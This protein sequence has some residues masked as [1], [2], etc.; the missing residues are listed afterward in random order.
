MVN[1]SG[2]FVQ[3]PAEVFEGRETFQGLEPLGE[4]VEVLTKS[5]RRLRNWSWVV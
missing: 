4:V 2:S 3:A 1:C 5:A